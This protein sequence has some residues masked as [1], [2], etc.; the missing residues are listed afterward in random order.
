MMPTD[1]CSTL[2]RRRSLE[3]GR[4]NRQAD[5]GDGSQNIMFDLCRV[6][7]Q[8]N[9]AHKCYEAVEVLILES[10]KN[11]VLLSCNLSLLTEDGI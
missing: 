6:D 10:V 7:E 11:F 2:R 5:G 8:D 3:A 4:K 9:L 1:A